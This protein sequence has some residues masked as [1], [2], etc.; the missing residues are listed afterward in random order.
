[1][2]LTVSATAR[3]PLDFF[4]LIITVRLLKLILVI[5]LWQSQLFE[6]FAHFLLVPLVSLSQF[7]EHV[8]KFSKLQLETIFILLMLAHELLHFL[9]PSK[10]VRFFVT[11]HPSQ[12]WL[13]FYFNVVSRNP[14]KGWLVH[15]AHFSFFHLQIALP[16][17]PSVG[18]LHFFLYKIR[19]LTQ[20][21]LRAHLAYGL[22]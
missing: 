20:C 18:L 17:K 2:W 7:L 4:L 3:S 19:L 11:I 16:L 8:L 5:W 1:M 21:L 9:T 6:F 22:G 10:A 15:S 13:T 14:V 12:N